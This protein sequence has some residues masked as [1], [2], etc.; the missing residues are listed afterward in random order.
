[1]KKRLV[2]ERDAF[3]EGLD[4]HRVFK[5]SGWSINAQKRLLEHSF[6][7][8]N[9][10]LSILLANLLL[11]SI[12]I[13]AGLFVVVFLISQEYFL[14]W[15][16]L[17]VMLNALAFFLIYFTTP[18]RKT[19]KPT[20]FFYSVC[21]AEALDK[22]ELVEGLFYLDK[23]LSFMSKF[24]NQEKTGIR[25]AEN[26]ERC[27]ISCYV[28]LDSIFHSKLC[29]LKQQ[30]DAILKTVD[31]SGDMCFTFANNFYILADSL[32]SRK[33]LNRVNKSLDF[34]LESSEKNFRQETYLERHKNLNAVTRTTFS[35]E[36]LA[37]IIPIVVPFLLWLMFG[38]GKV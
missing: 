29:K 34:I 17:T 26:E 6:Y 22:A 3:N 23:L 32:F 21:A 30:K 20:C 12:A 11:T 36:T 13:S 4:A 35:A 31:E 25:Y 8:T 37:A 5:V 15:I 27:S 14:F 24:S 2:T 7:N 38:Y 10:V 9:H 19:W 16:L 18:L 1:M 33:D 28:N